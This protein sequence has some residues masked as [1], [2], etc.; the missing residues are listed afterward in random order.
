MNGGE[1]KKGF[2]I[3]ELLIVVVVIAIL[4]AIT[5]V[6]YNGIQNR[7]KA[8]GAAATATQYGKKLALNFQTN[9]SQYPADTTAVESLLNITL[10][11]NDRYIVDNSLSPAQF[12][13]SI[14]KGTLGE[15]YASTSTSIDAVEGSCVMNH[16]TNPSFET[17]GASG[18]HYNATSSINTSWSTSGTSSLQ[19]H[20]TRTGNGEAIRF[21]QGGFGSM[22]AFSAGSSYTFSLDMRSLGAFSINDSNQRVIRFRVDG[23]GATSISAQLPNGASTQ[24]LVT[25][26][27]TAATGTIGVILQVN[28]WG[29]STDPDILVD[30]VMV[31]D[32][33]LQYSYGDGESKGWWWTGTPHQSR[34]V[35]PAKVLN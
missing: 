24:R 6:S 4:A 17:T 25:T 18:T 11:A 13:L 19:V 31:T 30:S 32:G 1:N 22:G 5:I 34:S 21:I 23:A 35:G 27:S 9:N 8:S 28:H 7:A 3:V 33:T 20:S 16:S 2:T 10:G 14:S 15:S 29:T 12:C 26:G